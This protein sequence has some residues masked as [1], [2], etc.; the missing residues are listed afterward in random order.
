[1]SDGTFLLYIAMLFGSGAIFVVLAAGGFGL[2]TGGRILNAIFGVGYV[3]YSI[4]L[5]FFFEGGMVRIF[6]YAFIA[7]VYA[8]IK[9]YRAWKS[10]RTQRAHPAAGPSTVQTPFGAAPLGMAV[11]APPT[12]Y[13][14]YADSPPWDPQS[15]PSGLP[16][17][18]APIGENYGYHQSASW[19][20]PQEP[21]A[22]TSY[23]PQATG[24]PEDSGFR[25]GDGSAQPSGLP[26]IGGH[27][28]P[29]VEVA[30]GNRHPTG[31]H[32]AY[33]RGETS[34]PAQA[35]VHRPPTPGDGYPQADPYVDWSQAAPG[36]FGE[37]AYPRFG[38]PGFPQ[39]DAPGHAPMNAYGPRRQGDAGPVA[40]PY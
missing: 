23:P 1:M 40:P 8:L 20:A 15:Q 25:P 14:V 29:Q 36:Q 7:P 24:V 10:S 18:G 17:R 9:T 32:D 22:R 6:I 37:Q 34:G 26:S 38:E 39:A 13:P 3:G 16:G 27:G 11:Q 19:P 12:A 4:Y 31:R 21:A 33:A 2:R 5:L 30:G 28:A 35:W